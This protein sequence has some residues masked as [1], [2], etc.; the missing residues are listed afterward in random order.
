[1]QSTENS[2]A[3]KKKKELHKSASACHYNKLKVI[4]NSIVTFPGAFVDIIESNS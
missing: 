2:A 1:M 3:E 4:F